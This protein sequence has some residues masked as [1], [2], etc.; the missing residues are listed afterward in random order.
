MVYAGARIVHEQPAGIHRDLPGGIERNVGAVHGARRWASKFTPSLSY[1]LPWHGH[2]NLFSAGFHS[3]V[4]PRWVQR[5][6]MTKRRSGSRT[7]QTR[8][9]IRIALVNAETE[10]GGK[11]DVEGGIGFVQSAGKEKAEEHQQ[12]DAEI[13]PDTSPYNSAAARIDR[14][15]GGLCFRRLGRLRFRRY[16]RRRG[17]SRL[18]FGNFCHRPVEIAIPQTKTINLRWPIQ[19]EEMNSGLYDLGDGRVKTFRGKFLQGECGAA[20]AR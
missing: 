5:A 4:Q 20:T 11:A 7:T 17:L 16:W 1:P 6:K 15:G 2:L 3:G 14:L 9:V 13:A 19:S 18:P 12:V 8:L 10:I